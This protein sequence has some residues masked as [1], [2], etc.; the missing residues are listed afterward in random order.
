MPPLVTDPDAVAAAVRARRRRRADPVVAVFAMPR[1]ARGDRARLPC[2]RFPEDA[3]RALGRAARYGA[4]RATPPGTVPELA[5]DDGRAAAIIADAPGARARLAG[6][7]GDRRAARLLRDRRSRATRSS[8]T[9]ARPAR[10]ARRWR[11]PIALKGVAEGLVHRSDAGAV[12]LGLR[13]RAAIAH[14]VEAMAAR[15]R[16]AGH[17]ARPASSC[18][19]WRPPG[20][21][22]LVGAV[23]DPTFGPVVAVAAGGAA[24]ELLGDSAVRLAPLT[25]RDA[26]DCVRELRTFP[27]LDGYRGAPRADVA[28]L[29]RRPAARSAR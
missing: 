1:G 12:A 22:M 2:F 23:V 7:G 11:R 26:H 20:V 24:T 8:P 13:G 25:E 18:R 14:A 15:M 10:C 28:A 17:R 9:P 4:W 21:E 29:E 5:A 6:A 3:A 27:L 19:R 16:A